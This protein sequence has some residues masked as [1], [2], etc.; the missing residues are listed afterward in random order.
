MQLLGK[1]TGY[2]LGP[3]YEQTPLFKWAVDVVNQL[4]SF[5]SLSLGTAT[6]IEPA[7]TEVICPYDLD[8]YQQFYIQ[9]V[10]KSIWILICTAGFHY[11]YYLLVISR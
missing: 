8:Y 1:E 10:G 4:A 7:A 9:V 6:K 5:C 2:F 11:L 3:N